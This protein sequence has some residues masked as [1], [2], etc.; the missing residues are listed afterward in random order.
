[1]Y[2]L[3]RPVRFDLRNEIMILGTA[4]EISGTFQKQ[5]PSEEG[6]NNTMYGFDVLTMMLTLSF[7]DSWGCNEFVETLH[8][9]VLSNDIDEEI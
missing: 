5:T 6:L 9:N 7:K 3:S 8:F 4:L 2:Y 1:M